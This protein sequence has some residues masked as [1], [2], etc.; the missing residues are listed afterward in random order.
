MDH[1]S[2]GRLIPVWARLARAG[3]PYVR[4]LLRQEERNWFEEA[5][6]R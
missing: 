6:L 2:N 3:T 4:L 1:I 5:V